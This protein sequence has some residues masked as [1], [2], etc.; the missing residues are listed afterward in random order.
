MKLMTIR[1]CAKTGIIKEHCLRKMVKSG[2]VKS[3]KAGTRSY[4]D[5]DALELQITALMEST[6]GAVQDG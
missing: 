4:V 1:E 5:I 2:Q 3:I 6:K